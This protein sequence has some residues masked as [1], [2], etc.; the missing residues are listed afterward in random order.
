MQHLSGKPSHVA[1]YI[2]AQGERTIIGLSEDRLDTVT[3]EGADLRPTDIVVFHLWRDH[4][5]RDLERAK[6]AGCFT[7]VGVEALGTG[8]S[9]DIA[10]GSHSD[11]TP[12]MNLE[13]ELSKFSFIVITQGNKGATEYS[14]FG[15]IFHPALEVEA[16]DATGAGDAFL[17]GYLT[18]C[19]SE[20]SDSATRL[21]YGATWAA[22][23]VQSE[24][25]IPPHW[26]EVAPLLNQ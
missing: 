4:F 16:I 17:A 15:E 2:D 24:S 5:A 23:A 25:S 6:S 11:I 8:I 26:N 18:A 7:V 20:I 22:L 21:N 10:I 12:E 14:K 19:A 1:I 3:L 13:D 9:A